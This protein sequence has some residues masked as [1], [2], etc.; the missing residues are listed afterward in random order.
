MR[1]QSR[2]PYQW[3][4]STSNAE[5]EKTKV[6]KKRVTFDK[7]CLKGEDVPGALVGADSINCRCTNGVIRFGVGV[8]K[9]MINDVAV[10]FSGTEKVVACYMLEISP[11][12]NYTTTHEKFYCMTEGGGLYGYDTS[13][14]SFVYKGLL[15]EGIKS[16]IVW[17]ETG[18]YCTVLSGIDNY[19]HI[20]NDMIFTVPYSS[21]NGTIC[22]CKNRVFLGKDAHYLAY[23]KPTAPWTF[24]DTF[25]E[26]GVVSLA[27]GFGKIVALITFDNRVY[28]FMQRGVA[29]VN[30]GGSDLDFVV[31]PLHYSGGE[32]YGR[33]VGICANAIFFLA[34]DGVYKFDG[35]K[36]SKIVKHLMIIP[37]VG[38]E[39]CWYAVVGD[40]YLLRYIDKEDVK[41]TVVISADG[42]E[43][44]FTVDKEGLSLCGNSA[45]CYKSGYFYT[46]EEDEMNFS[47]ERG[48]FVST[49]TDLN[50]SNE[51]LI[52]KIRVEGDG[53][54]AMKLYSEQGSVNNSLQ[55]FNG[56]A[57][58]EMQLRGKEF[59]FTFFLAKRSSVRKITLEYTEIE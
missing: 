40:N 16:A 49:V 36:F 18:Q 41:K 19:Y 25:E 47:G 33:S 31:Q 20:H 22:V 45:F 50:S 15:A 2:E 54:V 29:E 44:F 34:A 32:I 27:Y 51:K 52:S 59:Y 14:A 11:S 30:V 17:S 8:K 53:N 43:G 35:K 55:F 10:Q 9:Y 56:C 58:V 23:S 7:F 37:K 6:V 42:K 24:F 57:T 1:G 46:I 21:A 38:E 3:K 26:S 39:R 12:S 4:G 28:A 48:N 5:S 13:T